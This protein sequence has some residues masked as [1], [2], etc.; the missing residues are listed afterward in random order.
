MHI[1]S[2]MPPSTDKSFRIEILNIE[3]N[4]ASHI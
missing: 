1:L 4:N 2:E 3:L